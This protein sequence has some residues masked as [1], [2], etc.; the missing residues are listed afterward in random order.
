MTWVVDP[1]NHDRLLPLGCIGELLLEGPLVGPGYLDD[2]E[3][4]A[5]SFV[6]DP[7]WLLRGSPAQPGRHGR[8]YMTGD[9]VR[10]NEDGSLSFIGRKDTQVKIRGQRVELGE[11]ENCIQDCM[12]EATQVV[13]RSHCATGGNSIPGISSIPPDGWLCHGYH[14]PHQH[15]C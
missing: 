8:L 12:P 14:L 2:P 15:R 1:E 4:T 13:A 5:A 6:H 9:L 11:V 7:I 3:R 10:Y